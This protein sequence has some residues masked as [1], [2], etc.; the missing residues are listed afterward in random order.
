MVN[1]NFLFSF[2]Q[3]VEIHADRIRSFAIIHLL[4]SD[5]AAHKS[6]GYIGRLQLHLQ[7]EVIVLCQGLSGPERHTTGTEIHPGPDLSLCQSA[8]LMRVQQVDFAVE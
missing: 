7:S 8:G 2:A 3:S 6:D 5:D 4:N 1:Q